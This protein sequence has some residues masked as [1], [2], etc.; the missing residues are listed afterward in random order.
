[1]ALMVQNFCC[2]IPT[3]DGIWKGKIVGEALQ[4]V[5][6]LPFE[7]SYFAQLLVVKENLLQPGSE[8]QAVLQHTGQ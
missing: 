1:M 3:V 7:N 5:N 8:D 4:E 6:R 2:R